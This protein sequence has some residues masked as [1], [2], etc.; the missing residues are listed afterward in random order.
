[1]IDWER[2]LYVHPNLAVKVNPV[3]YQLL[4]GRMGI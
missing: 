4:N 1:M 3:F 2:I